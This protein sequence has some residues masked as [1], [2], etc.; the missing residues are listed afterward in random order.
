M[1]QMPVETRMQFINH[2]FTLMFST[3]HAVWTQARIA[4]QWQPWT[5]G[6]P[7]TGKL[8][9]NGYCR[10]MDVTLDIG[11]PGAPQYL[12]LRFVEQ[13]PNKET[14]PGSGV[15]KETAIR[16]R[17][18]ERLMWVINQDTNQFLGSVQNGQWLQSQPRATYAT[19][20]PGTPAY[21][22]T[23]APNMA[24][25]PSYQAP[26]LAE[27]VAPATELMDEALNAEMIPDVD[28]NIPEFIEQYYLDE[29]LEYPEA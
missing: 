22:P 23:P 28:M 11:N 7:I 18:G 27:N 14:F 16:A 20:A 5:I 25:G 2:V 12:R 13:N 4:D 15:L 9:A 26:E 10:A 19:A 29:E 24:P 8:F 21:A 3:P 17:R 6:W 1:P